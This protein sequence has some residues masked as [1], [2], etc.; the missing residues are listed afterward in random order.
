MKKSLGITAAVMFVINFLLFTCT[1][2]VPVQSPQIQFVEATPEHQTTFQAHY[3]SLVGDI[4]ADDIQVPI[5]LKDRVF[6][7]TGT[8]CVW[9]SLETLGRWAE[10]PK[11]IDPPL[12][13]RS[14][15]RT[16]AN[17]SDVDHVL[18]QLGVKTAQI[19]KFKRHWD[20]WVTVIYPDNEDK[21]N[22]KTNRIVLPRLL[23]IIDRNN[24]QGTYPKDYILMPQLGQPR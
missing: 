7:K 20:T 24:P 3:T 16:Y 19:S 10:E 11:L 8:Q 1:G 12:S 6:N 22:L 23:P 21:L 15:C 2:V 14:S 13:S 18:H 5:P 9:V 17:P 4:E